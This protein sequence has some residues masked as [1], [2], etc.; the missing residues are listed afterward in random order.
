MTGISKLD[1][2]NVKTKLLFVEDDRVDQY[3][4]KR[5]VEKEGWEL[6]YTIACS[7]A[8][9]REFLQADRFDVIVTDYLLGDGNAF[10]ILRRAGD[11]PV[12]VI[13]A[14]GDEELAVWVMKSGACDYLIKDTERQYIKTLPQAV[15]S[16]LCS[17][18]AERQFRMFSHALKTVSDSVW[19]ADLNDNLIF[20]NRAFLEKFKYERK[21]ALQKNIWQILDSDLDEKRVKAIRTTVKKGDWHGEIT[22]KTHNGVEFPALITTSVIFSTAGR[23]EAYTGVIK[24]ISRLRRNATKQ[25]QEPTALQDIRVLL[26]EDDKVDQMAFKRM[27]KQQELAYQYKIASS[28]A[29]VGAMLEQ[30][31]FD[32]VI[33]DYSLGD[34]SAFD[35]IMLVGETPLIMITGAGDEEIAVRAMKAGAYDYVIKDQQRNYLKTLPMTIDNALKNKNGEKRYKMLSHALMS[36]NDSVWITDMDDNVLFINDAFFKSFGYEQHE[37]LGKSI[38]IIHSPE[39]PAALVRQIQMETLCGGWQGELMAARKDGSSFPMHLSTSVVYDD[40]NIPLAL[41]GVVKNISEQKR[42]HEK[43]RE[44]KELAEETSRMKSE[45]LANMSHEIR[46]PMNGIIGMTELALDTQLT[47]EQTEYLGMVKSSAES[48]LTIINDILDFSK[49]EAGKLEFISKNFNLHEK[50]NELCKSLRIRANQKDLG[51]QYNIP[52]EIPNSLVGDAGRLGQVIINLVGNAIKFTDSG[53]VVLKVEREW[54]REH[55]ICL[56]F[57]VI[58]SGIGILPHEQEVIFKAFRQADSS[59]SR[60]YGGTGLGLAISVKL[61]NLMQGNIWVE[62]PAVSIYSDRGGPGSGFHFLA[63]FGK[64][65]SDQLVSSQGKAHDDVTSIQEEEMLVPTI[66]DISSTEAN[67]HV[68]RRILVAEDNIVN[69]KL[70]MRVLEMHN[71]DVSLVS[72]GKQALADWEKNTY[73]LILMDI[74]MPEMNGIEATQRIREKE[75]QGNR[76]TPIIALTANAMKGDRERFLAA[77]MD[78]YISKPINRRELLEVIGDHIV[79]HDKTSGKS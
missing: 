41:T 3:I 63:V 70:V 9:A 34:G 22:C 58:D 75:A 71:F 16:A 19:I 37:L 31:K 5:N 14:T 73:D 18:N 79:E 23:P 8:Q 62:S 35:V 47:G 21:A 59:L 67:T 57:A 20:V 32:I 17:K 42:V 66:V 74:Q 64:K 52:V 2:K 36:I 72:N 11:C 24:D 30:E 28:V 15:E 46:T 10:D 39:T 44:A 27:V 25:H 40:K 61:I 38:A 78:G 7:I 43:L 69:Q 13:T 45:F 6:D 56:H 49:I 50:M 65:S 68:R 77:G 76:R 51:F 1:K 48:L 60:E 29:E 55:E 26:V 54:E 4:F 33:S 12:I 53:G